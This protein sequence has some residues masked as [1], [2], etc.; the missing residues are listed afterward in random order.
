MSS[1]IQVQKSKLSEVL[2]NH[3]YKID[4]FQRE[5]KWQDPQIEALINDLTSCFYKF[6]QEGDT[7]E[8]Y[9]SYGTYFMGSIVLC[10]DKKNNLSIVD[11]QQRLT[12]FTILL[13]FLSHLQEQLQLPED[14]CKNMTDF[15]YIKKGGQTSY[16]LNIE[17]RSD[18]MKLIIESPDSIYQRYEDLMSEPESIRNIV[19]GY[20]SIRKFFPEDMITPSRLP[21]FIEWLL[22]N[23]VMV[24]IMTDNM[25]NAYTIF[26]TMNDRGLNLRPAEI[27]KGY[28]LS[29]I[30]ET[31]EPEAERKAEEANKFWTERLEEMQSKHEINDSDYFRAWLRSKYAISQRSSKSGSSNEDFEKIGANFHSWV[32]DNTNRMKLKT[33]DDYFFF[34]RSDFD[35]YSSLYEKIA[36]SKS[37]FDR[38][39][40]LL[41]INSFWTIA[42]SLAFPLLMAPV[43]KI[44][45]N[46]AIDRKLSDVARYIDCFANVRTLQ[47]RN[48]TQTSIRNTIFE[49]VKKIR[50]VD[51]DTLEDTLCEE[52]SKIMKEGEMI[53]PFQ[54]MNNFNYYHYFYARIWYALNS[55]LDF[56]SLL[57]SRKQ[58]SYILV[59]MF[60]PEDFLLD[61]NDPMLSILPDSIAN[62]CLLKR[63]NA[64]EYEAIKSFG[65]KIS[66]L[67]SNGCFPEIDCLNTNLS[68]VEL[69][70]RRD[71]AIREVARELWTYKR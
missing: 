20:M 45:D 50:N 30:V 19:K 56:L 58:S 36:K 55:D 8:S 64:R 60:L 40:E 48:I 21:L 13:V 57:R 65:E 26:E 17:S 47:N 10:R 18:I 23:V 24:E 32:K 44:D 63:N 42:D 67:Y 37:E 29:K 43:R 27:L 66:Y 49:L 15:L 62:Y 71:N 52:S 31:H 6:F 51:I 1:D 25:D 2:Y 7:I 28:L 16:I 14:H 3:R 35:Y 11:G 70:E 41:Y 33:A 39:M 46:M 59:R 61:E 69:I 34:I 9:E 12:T 38:G 54:M 68:P 53:R 5:Y 4:V 22:D